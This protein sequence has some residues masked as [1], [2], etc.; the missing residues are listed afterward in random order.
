MDQ[1]RIVVPD[2]LRSLGEFRRAFAP[3]AGAIVVSVI[4]SLVPLVLG[5]GLIAVAEYWIVDRNWK[6]GLAVV[7][8]ALLAL[9]GVRLLIRTLLRCRQT[10]LI[11]EKGMAIWRSGR[12]AVFRWDQI[13]QVEAE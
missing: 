6:Y 1:T 10:V 3:T 2:E 9:Q 11:F 5:C 8:G 13:E 4:R 7:F 12:L